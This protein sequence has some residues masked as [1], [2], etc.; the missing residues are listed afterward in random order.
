[1][2]AWMRGEVVVRERKRSHTATQSLCRLTVQSDWASEISTQDASAVQCMHSEAPDIIGNVFDIYILHKYVVISGAPHQYRVIIPIY[3]ELPRILVLLEVYIQFMHFD[4]ACIS[5]IFIGDTLIY[6]L[7]NNL[8]TQTTP[9][10][11]YAP[12]YPPYCLKWKWIQC[13]YQY[14]PFAF[15]GPCSTFISGQ[16]LR[17]V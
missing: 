5:I 15:W 17:E 10:H 1:M 11:C 4:T 12:H 9:I 6:I 7:V 13:E 14:S 2:W 16:S 8:Y 3:S